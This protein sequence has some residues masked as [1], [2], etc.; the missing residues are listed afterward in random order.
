MLQAKTQGAIDESVREYSV[1]NGALLFKGEDRVAH[2]N[3][4]ILEFS[5]MRERAEI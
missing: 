1:N 3:G 2:G 5:G 4:E